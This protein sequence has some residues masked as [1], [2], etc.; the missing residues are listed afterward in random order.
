M[1][2]YIVKDLLSNYI[3]DLTTEETNA[4][5]K[6]H[7]D[8]CGDCHTILEKMSAVIPQVIPPEDINIDFIKKL[9][10][11][12]LQRNVIVAVVTCIVVL[13]G[14]FIFAKNY[15]IPLPFDPNRMSVEVFKVA[16]ITNEDGSI[17]W[18]DLERATS[19]KVVVPEGSTRTVLPEDYE[20]VIDAVRIAYKGISKISGSSRGRTI[21]RNGENV[22]V[23]YYCYTKT[24]WDSLFFDG[25]LTGYSES[26]SMFGTDI[27]GDDFES[28]DYEQQMREIYYLPVKSLYKIDNLS[29]EEFDELREKCYLIWSGVI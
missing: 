8:E 3:D 15:E 4:D 9:K 25:D 5:I 16:V 7:L 22:T 6:K 17:S 13:A 19:T 28:A 27:Y 21:N 14:L 24:L 23:V 1:K 29:D 2:C 10:I 11:K 18:K 12:M 20:N 26:G